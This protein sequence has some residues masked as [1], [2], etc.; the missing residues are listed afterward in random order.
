MALEE[1][2]DGMEKLQSNGITAWIDTKL[3]TFLV[4]Q[5]KITVDYRR[6]DFG[7]GGY[8]LTAGDKDCSGGCS[9]C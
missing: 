6:D 3:K 4:Q 8:I 5:G 2:I 7:G 9:G 1:S